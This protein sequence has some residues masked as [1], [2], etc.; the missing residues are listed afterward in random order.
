MVGE[1][2]FKGRSVVIQQLIDVQKQIEAAKE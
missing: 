2:L 1:G